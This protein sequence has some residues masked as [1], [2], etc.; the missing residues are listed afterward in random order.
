MSEEE[1]KGW[2]KKNQVFTNN[3]DAATDGDCVKQEVK[4]SINCSM[5][6]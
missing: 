5:K 2:V 3:L 4:T 6:L 1:E